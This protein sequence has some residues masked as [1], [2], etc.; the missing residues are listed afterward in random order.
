MPRLQYPF[1]LPHSLS[2][3]FLCILAFS[4]IQF[5]SAAFKECVLIASPF[6]PCLAEGR[7]LISFFRIRISIHPSMI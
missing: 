1:A 7:A 3:A 6:S 4:I 2:Q 5:L